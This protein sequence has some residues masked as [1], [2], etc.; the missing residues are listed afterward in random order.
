[1]CWWNEKSNSV[2]CETLRAHN[3][4]F[5]IFLWIVKFSS[6]QS[7]QSLTFRKIQNRLLQMNKWRRYLLVNTFFDETKKYLQLFMYK[8]KAKMVEWSMVIFKESKNRFLCL[9][10]DPKAVCECSDDYPSLIIFLDARINFI[11]KWR[12]TIVFSK[13]LC[14]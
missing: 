8:N 2:V 13:K 1:M 4:P 11:H 10:S 5:C 6:A 9:C 7:Y 14:K 12:Y 3:V